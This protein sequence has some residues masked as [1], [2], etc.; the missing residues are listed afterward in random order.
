MKNVE[1]I[2]DG[3]HCAS[4]GLQLHSNSVVVVVHYVSRVDTY[5]VLLRLRVAPLI[6]IRLRS[7]TSL[8]HGGSKT[9]PIS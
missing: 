1:T 2:L 4:T 8:V 3:T 9:A 6:A 5:F 7:L